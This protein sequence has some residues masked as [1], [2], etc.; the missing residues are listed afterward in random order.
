MGNIRNYVAGEKGEIGE[1]VVIKKG[2]RFKL[3]P[4]VRCIN[5]DKCFKMAGYTCLHSVPHT[6]RCCTKWSSCF[7]FPL[8]Q[9]TAVRCIRI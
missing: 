2:R 3:K 8:G 9:E 1:A 7:E 4:D 5:A 6:R